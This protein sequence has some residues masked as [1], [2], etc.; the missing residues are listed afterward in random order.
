M[1]GFLVS[2][3]R[4]KVFI[5]GNAMNRRSTAGRRVQIVSISWPSIMNLLNSFALT[6]E[7]MMYMVIT[8]IRISTIIEW[9]WKNRSCSMLG[10]V[11]S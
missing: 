8:V 6:T 9:S 3:I 2:S 4:Y 11:E 1:L 7:M 10:D 5:E